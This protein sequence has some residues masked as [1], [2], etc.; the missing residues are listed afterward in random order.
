MTDYHDDDLIDE[1]AAARML[2]MSTA[3]LQ[4]DRWAGAS[5]PFVRMGRAIRYRVGTLRDEI[6][7]R[8]VQAA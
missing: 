3:W 5:V 1:R 2:G 8:T 6:R 4:R 7:K